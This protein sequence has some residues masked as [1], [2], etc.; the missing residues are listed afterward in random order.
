FPDGRAVADGVGFPHYAFA[1][2]DASARAVVEP[3]V[4]ESLAGRT[5]NPCARCNQHVKF[6]LLWRRA[7]ELGASHLATGHYARIATDPATGCLA[8][9]AAADAA[10]DQTY[11]LFGLDHAALARTLFPVGDLTNAEVR[12]EA[13]ACELPLAAN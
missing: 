10:K 11:F 2:R 3:F 9:R 4:A 1:F 13:A 12:A 6:D 5:P 8:L 7:R